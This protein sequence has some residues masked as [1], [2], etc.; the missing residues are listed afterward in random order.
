[1]SMRILLASIAILVSATVFSQAEYSF[2]VS[3]WVDTADVQNQRLLSVVDDFL[4]TKGQSFHSN[5]NWLASD[6]DRYKFPYADIG[7]IEYDRNGEKILGANVMNIVSVSEQEKLVKLG[8]TKSGENGAPAKIYIIY[9]VIAVKHDEGWK[10]K[11]SIDYQ[12]KD[13]QQFKEKSLTYFLPPGIAL[14]KEEVTRQLKDISGICQFLGMDPLPIA[15]YSCNTPKQ[16]F[17]VKGFDYHPS[18]FVS[19]TGGLAGYRN[20]IFSGNHSEYYTHEIMH[21]YINEKFNKVPVLLNEG[22]AT[23]VGGSGANSYSWHREKL[24]NYLAANTIDLSAYTNAYA[25]EYIDDETPIAYMVGALIC[26]RIIRL[27]GKEKLLEIFESNTDMWES[28]S[29]LGITKDNL[30]QLILKELDREFSF[31][32]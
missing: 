5:A 16:V 31:S 9:N 6:F 25:N 8:F 26:E 11:R 18:M 12:T 20:I 1:M 29:A 30:N 27:Y 2:S 4:Q 21:V 13:W 22:I 32:W 10:L 7:R 28:L 24:K 17:E 19:E 15:Y 3:P 14:N 23:L